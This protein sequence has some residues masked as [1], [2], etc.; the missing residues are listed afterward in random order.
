MD[1][2]YS[3]WNK[4]Q[5]YYT[6]SINYLKYQVDH[7]TQI[8]KIYPINKTHYRLNYYINNKEYNSIVKIQKGPMKVISVS[9]NN[10][11]DLF[12][13]L[14]TY[15]S[16]SVNVTPKLLGVDEVNVLYIDGDSKTF[17]CDDHIEL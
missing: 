15:R 9:D 12:E 7:Y 4:L 14:S 10:E 6:V 17:K 13:L 2:L 8:P 11:N 5:L 16:S 1:Y 3:M